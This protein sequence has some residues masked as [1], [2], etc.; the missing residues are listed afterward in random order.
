MN[1]PNN[2]IRFVSTP[3]ALR[4][5]HGHPSLFS[6]R[7]SVCLNRLRQRCHGQD[8]GPAELVRLAQTRHAEASRAVGLT[9]AVGSGEHEKKYAPVLCLGQ[10]K[11]AYAEYTEVALRC[12]FR[13][14]GES[15][16][17]EKRCTT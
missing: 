16:R 6:C 12:A 7:A 15:E 11:S 3:F 13:R 9:R 1:R 5:S 17:G 2:R 14:A 10:Q 4:V 8:R